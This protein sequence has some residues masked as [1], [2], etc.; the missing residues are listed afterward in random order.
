MEDA[1]ILN[2]SAV[3]RGMFHGQ[4][5]QV[6]LSLRTAFSTVHSQAWW[7]C[8]FFLQSTTSMH[9]CCSWL[10]ILLLLFYYLII[11]SFG[12]LV[13][14]CNG[15]NILQTETI[16]LTERGQS[17]FRRSNV[18]KSTHSLIDSDGLPY[19]GQVSPR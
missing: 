8:S 14:S 10:L 4:I 11:L 13:N 7:I 17:V 2:K 16:D 15:L 9:F 5:F 18:D 12:A 6:F 1:M 19:V 3:E